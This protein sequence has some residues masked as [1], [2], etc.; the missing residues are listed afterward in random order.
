MNQ[1]SRRFFPSIKCWKDKGKGILEAKLTKITGVPFYNTCKFTFEKL[2][3]D[4]TNI[5]P[6]LVNFMKGFSDKARNIIDSFGFE[7]QIEKLD[8]ADRLFLVVCKFAEMDLHPDTV[9]NTQM[10]YIFEELIRK[11][12]EASNEE[13]GDHF[14][15]REV[16]R[17]WLI[18]CLP[19]TK[20]F[21]P[22]RES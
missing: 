19:P 2:R 13:A 8:K 3:G 1:Q 16:I 20:T 4:P 22:R 7:D 5:A 14:T 10:G 6:N 11:F 12:N 17:L 21:S 15:P 18:C 9:P